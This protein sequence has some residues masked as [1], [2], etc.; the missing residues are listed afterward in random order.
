MREPSAR[1]VLQDIIPPP[2]DLHHAFLPNFP[3]EM[4]VDDGRRDCYL[5]GD[6]LTEVHTRDVSAVLSGGAKLIGFHGESVIRPAVRR[7]VHLNLHIYDIRVSFLQFRVDDRN[8]AFVDA[9]ARLGFRHIL[10]PA[11]DIVNVDMVAQFKVLIC[12]LCPEH[13]SRTVIVG[14]RHLKERQ[15]LRAA[16]IRF[17]SRGGLH[18][19]R[20]PG[21]VAVDD[22]L[23]RSLRIDPQSVQPV[24]KYRQTRRCHGAARQNKTRDNRQQ[25]FVKFLPLCH[26]SCIFDRFHVGADFPRYDLLKPLGRPGKTSAQF[27]C[28]IFI[29]H[30][31]NLPPH[32][33]RSP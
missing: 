22:G 26:P 4:Q 8:L 2:E 13:Q 10:K 1:R 7:S 28:K 21:L 18:D 19:D 5:V 23:L 31:H 17:R 12:R 3:I 24:L 27:I 32:N 16:A 14:V 20:F 6:D 25:C 9:A 29:A 11:V 30:S 33:A 15:L